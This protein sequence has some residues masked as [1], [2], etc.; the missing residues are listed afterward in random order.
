MLMCQQMTHRLEV[1]ALAQGR[2]R[3]QGRVRAPV[4]VHREAVPLRQLHLPHKSNAPHS[5]AALTA[6]C[7]Y[8]AC[9]SDLPR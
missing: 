5:E 6:G 2:V 8:P 1:E 9:G 3:P 4:L 7:P